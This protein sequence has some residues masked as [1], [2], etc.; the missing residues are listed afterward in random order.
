MP[1]R[2]LRSRW[3]LALGMSL[4]AGLLAPAG[5]LACANASALPDAGNVTTVRGSFLCLLNQERARYGLGP[6][7]PEPHLELAAQSHSQDMVSRR[8]FAHNTLGGLPLIPR[9]MRSGY[10]RPG[11]GFEFGEALGYNYG[12]AAA[13]ARMVAQLLASAQHRAKLLAGRFQHVGIGIAAG[14]PMAVQGYTGA[15]YTIDVGLRG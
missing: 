1:T 13:P 2:R 3:L 15:T 14:V 5:A 9:L 11:R 10:R 6:L 4:V 8:Y 12:D 7:A